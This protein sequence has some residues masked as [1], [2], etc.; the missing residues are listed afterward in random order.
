MAAR[1][2]ARIGLMVAAL[3]IGAAC[4]RSPDPASLTW[5]PHEA[6]NRQTHAFNVAVDRGAWGPTA[7]AYGGAVPEPV[8]QGVSNLR[9]HWR[10]PHHTIQYALQGRPGLAGRMALRFGINTTFGLGGVIDPAT[11]MGVPYRYTNVDETFFVWGLEEGGYLE[12]PLGGPGTERDWA[13]W[14]LDIAADPMT[15]LVAG[16]AGAA[17]FGVAALDVVNDRYALDA[18]LESILYDSADSYTALRISYLQNMRA[19]LQGEAD[20]DLLEDIY[21]F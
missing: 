21:D 8:R 17:L 1:T 7:R 20:L 13:G 5:D 9:E 18:A 6:Q 12:L 4:T 19:R 14:A 16:A 11:S 2:G 15:Y 3:A 10:L